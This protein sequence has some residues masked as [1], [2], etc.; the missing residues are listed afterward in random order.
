VQRRA[1]IT[2]PLSELPAV[3]RALG[4]YPTAA[5]ITALNNEARATQQAEDAAA[6]SGALPAAKAA[7]AAAAASSSDPEAAASE[8][9]L[10]AYT[11]GWGSDAAAVGSESVTL[12]TLLRLYV[13][14]RPVLPIGHDSVVR[15]INTV[16]ALAGGGGEGS[17]RWGAL[18]DLLASR[19]E[20]LE[21]PEL[22]ACLT[23]L[24]GPLDG[25]GIGSR[26]AARQQH[27]EDDEVLTG[28]E[29]AGRVLGLAA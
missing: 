16:A 26:V 12:P 4:Y 25:G 8:A 29:I 21:S 3:M 27:I 11:G 2:L 10:Q 5:E 22:V 13:N 20:T 6:S 28:E 14:H 9:A 15:S 1:G 18:A 19:A 24:M 17:V 7:A 23:A